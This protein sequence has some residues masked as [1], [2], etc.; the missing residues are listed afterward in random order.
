MSGAPLG[1]EDYQSVLDAGRI[2]HERGWIKACTLNEQVDAWQ[3]MVESVEKG[4]AFTIDAYTNDLDVRGWL[5]Q[6]RSLVTHPVRRSL[7]DRLAALDA[8]F[9]HATAAPGRHM[10]GAGTEWWFRV[11]NILVGEL[12]EDVE[13]LHLLE[14]E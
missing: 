6:A 5:D 14:A 1:P 13:R 7:D 2:L 3:H 9:M 12:H 4:Y 8:R 10:P 11:P